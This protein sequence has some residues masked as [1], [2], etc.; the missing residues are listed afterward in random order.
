VNI[1]RARKKDFAELMEVMHRAFAADRPGFERFEELFPDLYRPSSEVMQN[2]FVIRSNGRIGSV[3]GL[4][5]IMLAIGPVRL[6][7]AGVGGVCTVPEHR[8]KG[9]M[10]A[11]LTHILQEAQQAGYALAWLSGLRRRYARFGFERA[12]SSIIVRLAAP[13]R[14]QRP[15][16]W[17]IAQ[18]PVNA[19]T[20]RILIGLR[21][22]LRVRGLC[23]DNTYL[24][25]LSR[26]H[27]ETWIASLGTARA[28]L[29]V[30]R[31]NGW[32]LE[33]G[34][35]PE[36]VRALLM[37]LTAPAQT[38]LARLSP[39]RDEYTDVFLAL[40]EQYDGAQDALAVLNT[41]AL[42]KEYRPLLAS[43]WP[44]GKVLHLA[45]DDAPSC[46]AVVAAGRVVRRPLPGALPIHTTRADLPRLLFGPMGPDLVAAL[47]PDAAWLRQVLPLPFG[48]P[49]LWRV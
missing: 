14:D 8:G 18:A 43:I 46:H 33:W 45:A 20:A 35:D 5:P 4:F 32:C 42:L 26:K 2:L 12:G 6:R 19:D 15:L 22:S 30:N 40:C 21:A 16:P 38:W 48:M 41:P 7:I 44:E 28:Y 17:E 36:G 3:A 27:V 37:H 49:G 13:S 29:V 10:S 11:L 47:P 24:L 34:G 39:L 1:E 9:A 31:K 25:K 23:D